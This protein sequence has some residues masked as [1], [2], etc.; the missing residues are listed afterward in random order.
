MA[1]RFGVPGMLALRVMIKRF[2]RWLKDA[3]DPE[4]P[5]QVK[6]I[7]ITLHW[8]SPVEPCWQIQF[9]RWCVSTVNLTELKRLV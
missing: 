1:I 2:Y 7:K 6:W 9:H 5:R 3:E 4:Y 8:Y